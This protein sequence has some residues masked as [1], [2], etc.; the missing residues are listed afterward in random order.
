M[1]VS[2]EADKV[3]AV[4]GGDVVALEME[5]DVPEGYRVAVDIEGA[6]GAGWI[7]AIG[8][9]LMYLTEEILRE[10][11][12]C[13]SGSQYIEEAALAEFIDEKKGGGRERRVIVKNEI[14]TLA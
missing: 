12:G 10:V 1:C 9:G 6:N 13:W 3:C 2:K 14:N 4:P 11:R 8:F 7:S 5:G